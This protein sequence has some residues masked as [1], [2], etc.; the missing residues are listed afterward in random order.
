VRLRSLRLPLTLE[1]GLDRRASL[2]LMKPEGVLIQAARGG[3]VDE[4]ALAEA[5]ATGRLRGA[6]LDVFATEPPGASPLLGLANVVATPHLVP[7]RG[8]PG[9]RRR[10]V[11]P[12]ER[13]A[14]R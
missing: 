11:S 10:R 6:A 13:V 2:G 12:G 4:A 7:Y 1:P 14:G 9:S 3:I 8:S 5:L